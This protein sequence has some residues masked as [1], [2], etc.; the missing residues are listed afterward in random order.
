MRKDSWISEKSNCKI[1]KMTNNCDFASK[2]EANMCL[3]GVVGCTLLCQPFL[4]WHA[5]YG[6][7]STEEG[8][9][10][11][12]SRL[13]PNLRGAS[14]GLAEQLLGIGY[15]IVVDELTER[16]ALLCIDTA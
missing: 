7:E 16:D 3:S 1:T 11:R 5:S 15:A 10:V 6:F 14:V 12:E 4:R 13:H 8:R 9:L 2:K